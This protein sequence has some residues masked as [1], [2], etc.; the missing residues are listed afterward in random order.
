MMKYNNSQK[1]LKIKMFY[2]GMYMEV[3]D[4]EKLIN[5]FLSENSINIENI[6]ES[7]NKSTRW[8]TIYYTEIE[9]DLNGVL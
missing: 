6:I 3:E 4:F 9:G 7:T 2:E 5:K 8:L 1:D